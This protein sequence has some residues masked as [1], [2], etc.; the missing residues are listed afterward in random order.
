MDK[1][2]QIECALKG[3][4]KAG[5]L[6]RYSFGEVLGRSGGTAQ[7]AYGKIYD[8]SRWPPGTSMTT[9]EIVKIHEKERILETRNSY[10]TLGDECI[11][12]EELDNS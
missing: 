2:F 8:D 10:Y 1:P 5:F 3:K 11:H 7:V 6:D 9:S 4:H 12:T